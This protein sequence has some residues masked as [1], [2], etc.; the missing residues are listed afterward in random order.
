MPTIPGVPV[1]LELQQLRWFDLQHVTQP[2]DD[3]EAGVKRSFL[4]LTEIAA[5]DPL[6]CTKSVLLAHFAGEFEE[7]TLL[8]QNCDFTK[9]LKIKRT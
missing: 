8:C 1:V 6:G 7:L 3:L 2:A 4:E 9:K 5:T